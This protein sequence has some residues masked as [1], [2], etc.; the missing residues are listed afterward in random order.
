MNTVTQTDS[1]LPMTGSGLLLDTP[2][3]VSVTRPEEASAE[4]LERTCSTQ[5]KR[6][7]SSGDGR[8]ECRYLRC[9]RHRHIHAECPIPWNPIFR[10]REQRYKSARSIVGNQC[11]RYHIDDNQPTGSM[12]STTDNLIDSEEQQI[13]P[14]PGRTD[15]IITGK[16]ADKPARQMA[17]YVIG[18]PA[19]HDKRGLLFNSQQTGR[20][21][22]KTGQDGFLRICPGTHKTA[23][24]YV[25]V[26]S[27]IMAKKIHLLRIPACITRERCSRGHHKI[28]RHVTYPHHYKLQRW[29]L[30]MTS[31]RNSGEI[32]RVCFMTVTSSAASSVEISKA[33]SRKATAEAPRLVRAHLP[34]LRVF[35]TLTFFVNVAIDSPPDTMYH[36]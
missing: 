11:F 13:T 24:A 29:A 28:N 6:P 33:P 32:G 3:Q 14:Q 19:L 25:M 27:G 17:G 22:Y 20:K 34:L 7:L 18:S 26:M 2:T 21:S 15:A 5:R 4:V 31:A 36:K 9:G 1:L 12:F 23:R 8:K 30:S 16:L 10:T 35:L